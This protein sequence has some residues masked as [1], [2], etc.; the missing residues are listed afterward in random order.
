MLF[1]INKTLTSVFSY[2]VGFD[3]VSILENIYTNVNVNKPRNDTIFTLFYFP[4]R[5]G[6]D[7][8]DAGADT[9]RRH[10]RP[11]RLL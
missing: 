2:F 11:Q 5:R 1:T 3:A 8:E 6:G 9:R 7:E 4:D 10:Q